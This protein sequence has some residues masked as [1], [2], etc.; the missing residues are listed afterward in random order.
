MYDKN[1]R[2]VIFLAGIGAVLEFYDFVL[3]MVFSKE[4]SS[5]SGL[6]GKFKGEYNKK[7]LLSL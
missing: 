1:S 4:I 7:R 6:R 2:S 3:F 5:T